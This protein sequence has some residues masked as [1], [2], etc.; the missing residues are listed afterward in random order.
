MKSKKITFPSDIQNQIKG[1]VETLK[2]S[3][4]ASHRYSFTRNLG[5]K[6]QSVRRSLNLTQQELSEQAHIS[7]IALGTYERGE[8]TPPVDICLRIAN[9]LNISMDELLSNPKTRVERLCHWLRQNGFIVK[10][11]DNSDNCYLSIKE[12]FCITPLGEKFYLPFDEVI[13]LKQECPTIQDG[14]LHDTILKRLHTLQAARLAPVMEKIKNSYKELSDEILA[15]NPYF[16]DQYEQIS[17]SSVELSEDDIREFAE[18][19]EEEKEAA[20]RAF[21]DKTSE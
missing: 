10:A 18:E 16:F 14:S 3:E 12:S 2:P 8:R 19:E 6:I 1:T 4:S 11:S 17:A 20:E 5:E 7:R 13:S 15:V 9:A 21:T